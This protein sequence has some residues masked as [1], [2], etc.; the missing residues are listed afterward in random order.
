MAMVPLRTEDE[1]LGW[2]AKASRPLPDP[3]AV[4]SVTQ[5][6]AFVTAHSQPAPV[7]TS[8][9]LLPPDAGADTVA[10]LKERVHPEPGPKVNGFD[11]SLKAE[12]SG[13]MALTRAS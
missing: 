10:A 9:E 1:V 5:D 7:R 11:G 12:P 4:Q 6:G 2:T 8:T 13:P 3:P